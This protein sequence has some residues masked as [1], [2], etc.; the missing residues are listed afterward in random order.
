MRHAILILWLILTATFTISAAESNA[1]LTFKGKTKSG[2]SGKPHRAP[3][4][5]PI[6]VC[7]DDETGIVTV[8]GDSN[9]EAEVYLYD[10]AGCLVDYSP[11]LNTVFPVSETGIYTIYI[12]SD[13]WLAEGT[14]E[15]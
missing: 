6:D 4:H 8:T 3:I 12:E 7:Y 10:A 5:L 15:L 1:N 11:S 14:V 9:I 13:S 2:T